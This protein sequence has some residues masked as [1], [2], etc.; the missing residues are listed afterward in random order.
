MACIR[1]PSPSNWKLALVH[2]S[3][4]ESS[5]AFSMPARNVQSICQVSLVED[6]LSRLAD[7]HAASEAARSPGPHSVLQA[8]KRPSGSRRMCSA[9][10]GLRPARAGG[11]TMRPLRYLPRRTDAEKKQARKAAQR[12]WAIKNRETLLRHKREYARR[13][14]TLARRRELYR[15]HKEGAGSTG[16]QNFLLEPPAPRP[17][18]LDDFVKNCPRRKRS[19]HGCQHGSVECPTAAAL[20]G[21]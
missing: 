18:T 10:W 6:R 12:K 11:Q 1:S 13:P 7:A 15:L 16:Q 17:P 3:L 19:G 8:L 2:S 5:S 4:V 20:A 9:A 14:E 21:E